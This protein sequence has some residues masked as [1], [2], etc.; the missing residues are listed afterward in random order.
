MKVPSLPR[1]SSSRLRETR[2][3]GERPRF[4]SFGNQLIASAALLAI[5]AGTVV[6]T[7]FAPVQAEAAPAGNPG[8]PGVP[9]VLFEEDFEQGN[10]VTELEN[11]QSTT[12][13]SYTADPYWLDQQRCN[14]FILDYSSQVA[15]PGT[16]YCNA[17]DHNWASVRAKTYALGMLGGDPLT[18]RAVS[19][20]SS[21]TEGGGQ[22]RPDGPINAGQVQFAT[23]NQLQLPSA[24]RFVTFSVDTAATLCSAAQPN[25]AF[26]VRNDSGDEIPV[27]DSP[28]NPCI[29]GEKTTVDDREVWYGSLAA[30]NSILVQGDSLG[31]VMRNM[32]S[33]SYGNDGAFDN[34]RV[35][36]VTPQLDKSFSPARVPVGGI[37]TLTLT[38]TGTTAETTVS[39]WQFTD[40]LPEGL[41]V[42]DV[43]NLGGDC[44]ATLSAEP[45]GN[46]VSATDGTLPG[47]IVS[48]SITV[49][50]TSEQPR[51]AQPSPVVFENCAANISDAIGMDMPDCATVEFFSEAA[52]EIS[53][54]SDAGQDARVGD[55][56][57]Y[58]VQLTNTGTADFTA[59]SPAKFSD[60][61]AGVLDDASWNDD[62]E[63]AFSGDS[64][65]EAPDLSGT[66]LNWS[67]P[68]KAGETAT[69]TY[70]VT[71]TNTGDGQV[72][73][74]ACVP[75]ELAGES[76]ACA[77]TETLLPKLDIAKSADTTEL[78]ETGGTVNYT[79]TVTNNGPGAAT[80]NNLAT[81]TDDLSEV[82]DDAD[83]ND[84]SLTAS[85]GEATRDGNEL[86]WTGPLGVG[87]SA[88]ITY[89]VVYDSTSGDQQLD[90][91]VCVPAELAQDP[92]NPCRTVEI[93]GSGLS[94]WKTADP[95]SGSTV[96]PGQEVTYTLHF[97]N[98]GQAPARVDTSDDLSGVLDD[99]T[100][101][102]APA[103]GAG[104]LIAHDID[105]DGVFTI[106]G[107]VPVGESATIV[108]T[109][110]VNAFADQGD[111][112]LGN[113]LADPTGS[114]LPNQCE[115]EHEIPNLTVSKDSTPE[116]ANIGD[117][118]TYTITLLNDGAG[119]Y[120]AG[121]PAAWS[122]DLTGVLD[123]ATWNDDVKASS[124]DAVLDGSTLAWSGA[125]AAGEEVTVTYS[126]TVTSAGDHVLENT[127]CTPGNGTDE[128][129]CDTTTTGL[130]YVVAD[131]TSDPVSGE[132]V[133]AGDVVTYTLSWTNTGQAVGTVDSTDDL[134]EVLDDA[135]VTS[136]PVSSSDAVTVTRTDGALRIVGP[137]AAG[138]TVTVTYQVTVNA[139]GERGDN[140]L[141]N[142]LVPDVPP[143][144]EDDCV[145]PPVIHDVGALA[146]WK[147]VD[148][149]TNTTVREGDELTYTLHFENTGNGPVAVD[150]EDV[151]E[152]V[153]DDAAVSSGPTPSSD[154]LTVSDIADGRF[155]ITGELAAGATE[156]VTYTV[157]VKATED[158][159]DDRL[160]NFLLPPGT[161]VPESCVPAEGELPSCTVNP[162]SDI[163][164]SKSSDPE[165]GTEVV[166][167]EDV[168]YTLTFTNRSQNPGA[169]AAD[170]DYTDHMV[171][172]LDDADLTGNPVASS[173]KLAA[174]VSGDQIR[175]MGAIASGDTVTVTY[176]VTVKGYADQGNG[177]LGNVVA[178]TGDEP[179]CV[180]GSSLCTEHP[181]PELPAGGDEPGGNLPVTGGELSWLAAGGAAL[182]LAAGG[183]LMIRRKKGLIQQ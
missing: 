64:E 30:D 105:A 52:L 182:L 68:L 49:D 48:C 131:K 26:F 132:A 175:V 96:V 55:T 149:A 158:R 56:V 111:H 181:T 155:S 151:L 8:T 179:V 138:E 95:A 53:K 124:G 9:P 73:N 169:A 21:G 59:D 32:T 143:C 33:E 12:G 51:G 47:D 82:L 94:Q 142:A 35:L 180:P 119:D 36:D 183:A 135:T 38:V 170:V 27:T 57:N 31:I 20:N 165:S 17:E 98:T 90:N 110:Q 146:A 25:L 45:G 84:T 80:K 66:G 15:S 71:L 34:I 144:A 173:E 72:L 176:T 42:A 70:S 7:T 50:V 13:A 99:A 91:V 41:V 177:S 85:T 28:L 18:N 69:F 163:H 168:T 129:V 63:V 123:D 24:N 120:T 67:G 104:D 160:A 1:F 62:A 112:Q 128:P 172:V 150:R 171:D 125:L 148:P 77:S 23:E 147:S 22:N 152:G 97:A 115:T 100:V 126:V 174:T 116:A 19:S 106:T 145:P 40:N 29:Q 74:T 164:V 137:I 39:G 101:I 153:L 81:I 109:V 11:Y 167:G 89:S 14:G 5:L 114:C 136:E 162:V 166:P 113:V 16:N 3:R 61:L 4:Q 43:P 156:T 133:T 178:R 86:V 134:T 44:D 118:V 46:S 127:V 93:P 78:P 161:D 83:F 88:T 92:D 54:T 60:D 75:D 103:A 65:G 108:Y 121:N 10:G 102:S 141:T 6:V 154:A 139:D 2:A 87:E 130:P 140:Q 79:V 157:T 122:D 159:G 117:T 37:S 76:E 107:D 58:E